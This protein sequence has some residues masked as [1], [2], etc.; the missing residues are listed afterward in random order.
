MDIPEILVRDK[1]SNRMAIEFYAYLRD[2]P[3]VEDMTH[4]GMAAALN[5][6]PNTLHRAASLLSELGMIERGQGNYHVK[7]LVNG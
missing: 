5:V 6:S 3:G 4:Q 1:R 7:E 2:T